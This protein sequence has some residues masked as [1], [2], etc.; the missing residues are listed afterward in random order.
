MNELPQERLNIGVHAL[1]HCEWAFEE[2]RNFVTQR[3]AFGKTIAQ[4]QTVQHGLAELKT[5]IAVG[6]AFIDQC[7]SLHAKNQL[8][9]GM[10]SMSKYWPTDLE[11]RV[12]YKCVQMHGGAGY[13]WD[14]PIAKMYVDARVQPIYG[15]SNEIM[16]ELI[17]RQIV[18]GGKKK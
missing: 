12:A 17:A 13:L 8:D 14:T 6:R 3:K 9:S 10:A 11:N 15:G 16:K 4:L 5:E 2:T 18:G 1:A 7:I